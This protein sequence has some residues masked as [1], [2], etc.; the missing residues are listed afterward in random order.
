MRLGPGTLYSSIHTLLKEKFIEEVEH[1]AMCR[2]ATSKQRSRQCA[3]LL[4]FFT[5]TP[6]CCLTLRRFSRTIHETDCLNSTPHIPGFPRR[7]FV[8]R[9]TA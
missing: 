7:V 8:V 9:F 2:A 6:L 3:V 1:G 4:D 5:D